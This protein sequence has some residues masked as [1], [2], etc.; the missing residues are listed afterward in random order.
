MV[1]YCHETDMKPMLFI[2]IIVVGNKTYPAETEGSSHTCNFDTQYFDLKKRCFDIEKI[3][4][5]NIHF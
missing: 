3:L 2:F 1:C 5:P 4:G